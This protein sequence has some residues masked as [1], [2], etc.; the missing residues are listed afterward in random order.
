MLRQH[1]HA[2]RARATASYCLIISSLLGF[3][4]SAFAWQIFLPDMP[5][6]PGFPSRVPTETPAPAP[7][8]NPAPS[9]VA[10]P[11]QA[12]TDVVTLS[13]VPPTENTD[14]TQLMD[15]S[16]YRIYSGSTPA[17]LGAKVTLSNPGLTRYVID[18]VAAGDRY[19]AIVAINSKGLESAL[20][21][22]V[23]RD[24]LVEPSNPPPSPAPSTPT[25]V[26]P[27]PGNP[28]WPGVNNPG[29]PGGDSSTW[30]GDLVGVPR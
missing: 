26:N 3:A 9:P 29:W 16:G 8:P 23:G 27:A 15:L 24:A 28:A 11:P 12:G 17:K 22:V 19:F 5:G 6:F 7:T 21:E 20:S 4:H 13:W 25:P 1:A 10:P 14:G 30:P 18:S 2:R